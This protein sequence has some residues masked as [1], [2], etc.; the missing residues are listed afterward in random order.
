VILIHDILLG[1]DSKLT[2]KQEEEMTKFWK[3][4]CN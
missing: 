2:G 3:K 1:S 4:K